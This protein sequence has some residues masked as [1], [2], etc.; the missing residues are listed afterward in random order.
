MGPRPV[1]YYDFN[2]PYA[3]LAAERM[4]ELIPDAEWKPIAYGVVLVQQERLK[5]SLSRDPASIREDIDGRIGERGLAPFSPPDTWPFNSWSLLP[6]RAAVVADEHGRLT[7]FTLA[8]FRAAFHQGGRLAEMD[9]VLEVAREVGIDA[10]AVEEGVQRPEVKQRLK[11]HTEEA[12]ALPIEGIPT[13]DVNGRLF[14][15][16]DRLDEAAASSQGV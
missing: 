5:R 6:M 2:S 10:G 11:E 8:A 16:D 9:T 15:G 12:I 14:W 3:W 4:G 1:F 13:V 7:E